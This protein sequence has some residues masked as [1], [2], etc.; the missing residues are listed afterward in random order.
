APAPLPAKRPVVDAGLE[1]QAGTDLWLVGGQLYEVATQ[2]IA[3]DGAL[4][5]VLTLGQRLDL[6]AAGALSRL[7]GTTAVFD[8]P[9][10]PVARAPDQEYRVRE[11]PLKDGAGAQV[12]RLLLLRSVDEALAYL[13]R[14]QVSL[15]VA[16]CLVSLVGLA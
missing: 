13:R 2:P 4:I 12:G 6:A 10:D 14:I 8:P 1:F 16:A 11:L 15:A 9:G 3:F 5:A 7:T